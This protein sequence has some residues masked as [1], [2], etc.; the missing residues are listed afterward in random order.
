MTVVVFGFERQE[1]FM[2]VQEFGYIPA[3]T[4]FTVHIW[5][6]IGLGFC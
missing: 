2:I 1:E 4:V 6:Y 5:G 3:I